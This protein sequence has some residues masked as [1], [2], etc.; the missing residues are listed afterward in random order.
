[1]TLPAGSNPQLEALGERWGALPRP[2]QR[3]GAAQAWFTSQTFRYSRTPGTLPAV[4]GLDVFLFERREGF[5]GHYASAF[6]ALMR[7]AGVPARVVSGYLG[8]RW[9]Q[10]IGGTPYLDLR[11]SDAHA[12]SEVWLPGRGWQ[13]VD[14]SAWV[15]AS[16]LGA[17]SAARSGSPESN[18]QT[19]LQWQWWGLDLAWSR[20][21]LGFDQAGQDALLQRL[22]GEQRQALGLVLLGGV[23]GLLA[24]GLGWLQWLQ[25]PARGDRLERDLQAV[26]RHLRRWGIEPAPGETVEQ[27]C[28]RAGERLPGSREALLELARCHSLLRFGRPIPAARARHWAAWRT[29][30][31][32]LHRNHE[33]RL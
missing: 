30:L 16:A 7:A 15:G 26:V 18:W 4:Q 13:R 10:P 17:S 27:L 12:W 21:W 11:Q 25:A 20:W 9:V 3:V 14:P 2:E 6:T 24:L 8:G 31:H 19:W 29:A 32:A 28:L 23:G 5:C 33:S 22:F 1:L